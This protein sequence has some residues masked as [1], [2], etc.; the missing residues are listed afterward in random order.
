MICKYGC[1]REAM[2][3]DGSCGQCGGWALAEAPPETGHAAEVATLRANV[4]RLTEQVREWRA[5]AEAAGD[6]ARAEAALRREVEAERDASLATA[7]EAA[8]TVA[9]LT[10]LAYLGD[11]HF[12]DLTYKARLDEVVGDLRKAEAERDDRIRLLMELKAERD[13]LDCTRREGGDTRHCRLDRKCLR[14]R[15]EQA[16]AERDAARAQVWAEAV[17][18]VEGDIVNAE[19]IDVDPELVTNVHEGMIT[20]QGGNSFPVSSVRHIWKPAAALRAA[21]ERQP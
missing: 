10:A 4:A 3:T 1:G 16:E 5:E 15:L 7:T 9:R 14:C 17:A 12:P 18:V 8:E 6:R 2:M 21:Q 19:P 20:T 11:H 13:T